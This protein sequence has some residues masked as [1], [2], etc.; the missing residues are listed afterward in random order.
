MNNHDMGNPKEQKRPLGSTLG[1]EREDLSPRLII[2]FLIGLAIFGFFLYFAMRGLLAVADHYTE[3]HQTAKSPMVATSPETRSVTPSDVEKFPEP[4]LET[5]EPTEIFGFRAEEEKQLNSYG[6]VD[7]K[8]GAVH[9]PI[10]RA[11]D[12]IAERGL[13][14]T[15]KTGEFPPAEVNMVRAAAA[16]S[17]QS[18]GSTGLE[19]T[20][21]QNTENGAK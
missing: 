8:T 14:T 7:Q 20:G 16:R 18:G 11:M 13:P 2:S 9:I 1:F 4:R 19:K 15:P 3:Q 10:E 6:W 12:L 17:D 5:Y 21:V